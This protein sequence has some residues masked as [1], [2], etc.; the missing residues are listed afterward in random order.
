[1]YKKLIFILAFFVMNNGYSQDSFVKNDTIFLK[2]EN[3][4]FVEKFKTEKL[5]GENYK[6]YTILLNQFLND[7]EYELIANLIKNGYEFC[8]VKYKFDQ[9]KLIGYYLI[10]SGICKNTSTTLALLSTVGGSALV[11]FVNPLLGIGVAYVFAI[12]SIVENYQGNNYLKKA[13]ELLMK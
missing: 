5:N 4:G 8:V 11:Y 6:Y 13:G 1:M 10:E 9:N 7:S 12:I 2:G 3:V